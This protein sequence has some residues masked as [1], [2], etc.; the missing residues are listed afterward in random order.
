METKEALKQK[1]C[2]FWC[3]LKDLHCWRFPWSAEGQEAAAGVESR[4]SVGCGSVLQW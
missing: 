2:Y 1:S 4:G 3:N